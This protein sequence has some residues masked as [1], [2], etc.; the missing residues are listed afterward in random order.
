M[1]G[2]FA[3]SCRSLHVPMTIGVYKGTKLRYMNTSLFEHVKT[4]QSRFHVTSKI[5]IAMH[6]IAVTYV[7]ACQ[8]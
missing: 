5:S 7:Q 6:D 8:P 4:E 1:T 3:I 2:V